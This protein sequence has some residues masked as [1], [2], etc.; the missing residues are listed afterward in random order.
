[1]MN[2]V[3]GCAYLCFVFH[4]APLEME[5]KILADTYT[6]R[7]RLPYVHQLVLARLIPI[8]RD[9]QNRQPYVISVSAYRR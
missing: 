8:S 3:E 4:L 9:Q 5:A 6:S 7:L 1:M 2:K